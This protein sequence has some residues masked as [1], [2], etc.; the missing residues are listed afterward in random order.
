[1]EDY[2]KSIV[3]KKFILETSA[4]ELFKKI[5]FD[6]SRKYT[7]V[8]GD[9]RYKTYGKYVCSLYATPGSY[10]INYVSSGIQ[11]G[12]KYKRSFD[13]GYLKKN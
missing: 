1:M 5:C 2:S 8:I 6:K 10:F 4:E 3:S 13:I 11:R 7:A 12:F 9:E